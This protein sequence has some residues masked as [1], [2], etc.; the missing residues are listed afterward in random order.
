MCHIPLY[1]ADQQEPEEEQGKCLFYVYCLWSLQS[2]LKQYIITEELSD[3]S[4]V[5]MCSDTLKI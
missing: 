3:N 5:F 4:A 2:L 1:A